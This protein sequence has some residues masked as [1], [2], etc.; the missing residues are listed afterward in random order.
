MLQ[1]N[2]TSV[3]IAELSYDESMNT[4]T[5]TVTDKARINKVYD[6]SNMIRLSPYHTE[7][8]FYVDNTRIATGYV[9]ASDLE[10]INFD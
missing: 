7:V 9:H 10:D 2:I 1:E 5:I 4:R 6:D 8:N 3:E